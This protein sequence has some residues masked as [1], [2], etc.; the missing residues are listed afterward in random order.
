MGLMIDAIHVFLSLCQIN[1]SFFNIVYQTTRYILQATACKCFPEI[2]NVPASGLF[3][4]WN[5]FVR[6]MRICIII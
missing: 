3:D 1:K 6:S 5:S 2:R 4:V